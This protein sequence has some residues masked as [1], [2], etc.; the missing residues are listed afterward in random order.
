[1]GTHILSQKVNLLEIFKKKLWLG[2]KKSHIST[3]H[4]KFSLNCQCE[5]YLQLFLL[6]SA[7]VWF[8]PFSMAFKRFLCSLK[9]CC[10][11]L[12]WWHMYRSGNG[13]DLYTTSLCSSPCLSWGSKFKNSA[14]LL[15]TKAHRAAEKLWLMFPRFLLQSTGV[16][17]FNSF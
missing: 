14:N 9:V 17:T 3:C 1:M 12:W 13:L 10:I 15:N 5:A 4:F 11:H 6:N 2:K 16:E 8:V 7:K